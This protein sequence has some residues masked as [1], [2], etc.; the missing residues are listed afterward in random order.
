MKKSLVA[1]AALAA[2]TAFAQSSVELYGLVDIAY[3][4][5]KTTSRDGSVFIK[6]SG[7]MDGAHAGNRIGFRG[8]ED[9]GGG[10]KANFVVE[11]GISP[12]NGALF[13]VRGATAGHQYDGFSSA[14]SAAAASG[15]AGA[16]SQGTNRQSF[17]G[18]TGGMGTVRIGYQYTNLYEVSTLMGFSAGSEGMPGADK[19]HTHGNAAVG[20]T[21]ANG[22]TYISPNMNGFTAQLQM[23]GFAGREEVESNAAITASGLSVDKN[24]RTGIM[25]KYANGPLTLAYANTKGAMTTSA[26]ATTVTTRTNVYGALISA[27]STAIT[28]TAER[29]AKIDQL[30]GSYTMGAAKV[31]FT[32]NKGNNGGAATSTDITD[33]KSQQISGTY[34]FGNVVPFLSTGSAK[35]TNRTTAAL[36]EDYKLTQYGVRYN[37][38][39]RTVAYAMVGTTKNNAVAAATTAG[40]KDTKTAFGISHSF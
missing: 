1:L 9:L 2:T 29:N 32:Y 14:G 20:G 18:L 33:Y 38:S 5:H 39:K 26:L 25:I 27:P 24:K 15:T 11:Q 10:L 16:Y 35:S 6:S 34:A 4:N 28:N 21:R 31:G 37:M 13:G 22:I 12:T 23:G 7:V 36:S 40:H 3:G 8:T 19:A 30:G 17:V